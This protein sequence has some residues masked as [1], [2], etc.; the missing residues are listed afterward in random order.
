MP[1]TTSIICRQPSS[2]VPT[3]TATAAQVGGGTTAAQTIKD[4]AFS[5]TTTTAGTLAYDLT[6][7][8]PQ[9]G[10]EWVLSSDT[11]AICTVAGNRVT[12]VSSGIG[13]IR[14]SGPYGFSKILT[15]DF[16]ASATVSHVWVGFTGVSKSSQLSDPIL[17]L[18]LPA[19]QKNYYFPNFSRGN[20]TVAKNPN[21][22]AASINITGSPVGTSFGDGS[23]AFN[24]GAL[25]T[26]QHWVGVPHW[27]LT[28]NPANMGPGAT[29]SCVGS[30]GIVHTRTVVQRII[31]RSKDRIVS[32]LNSPFPAT[33]KPFKLAGSTMIDAPNQRFLGMGWQITQEKN[34]TPIG[35]DDFTIDFKSMST[36][37]VKWN[38]LFSD[39]AK[40]GHRMNGLSGL[41][42]KGRSG[43]S[44]GAIGGYYNGETYLVSLFTGSNSGYL[45]TEAQASELNAIIGSLDAA[46]GA[47]TGYTVGVLNVASSFTPLSLAPMMWLDAS[48][49]AT[50]YDAI[51]GGAPVAANGAIARWEDKSG[52]ARHATQAT[53]G[54]RPLKK[55]AL[56]NGL[57]IV[58]FDGIDDYLSHALSSVGDATIFA[59]ARSYDSTSVPKQVFGTSGS[60][61]AIKNY[62]VSQQ[63]ASGQWGTY[64][65]GPKLSGFT[66]RGGYRIIS[67]SSVGTSGSF[68][69]SGAI[70]SFTGSSFYWDIADRRSIGGTNYSTSECANCDIAEILVFPLLSASNRLKVEQYLNS[71]WACY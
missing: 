4:I 16:F 55:T 63:D 39:H 36:S 71:K 3:V 33:V 27:D 48:D 24:S 43:D 51:T 52:N 65:D 32:R 41:L 45:Y 11:P 13:I 26:P 44:G 34:I 49:A 31:D 6:Q 42:Q 60:W 64:R 61:E 54:A 14:V 15:L 46:Q 53:L 10:P 1:I 69:Q 40:S 47:A 22:W 2:F 58:R 12:K 25:I 56:L 17:A 59:V 50:L 5:V 18:L 19:K 35:F 21:C 8:V 67:L 30:D 66:L 68:S 20:T 62:I 37:S 23:M 7:V 38:S 70:N 28:D 29:I 9:F 57:P